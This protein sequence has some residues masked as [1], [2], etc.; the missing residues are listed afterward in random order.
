MYRVALSG[1]IRR[2]LALTFVLALALTPATTVW[3]QEY[4]VW[5]V[6]QSNAED[7]GDQL[8]IYTAG[9]WSEPSDVVP[10][11]A[12]AAGVGDGAGTRPHFLLFNTAHTHGLLANVASGHV[13]VIRASDRA[14]VASIDVGDQ[15]HAAMASPDDRWILVANQN[16]K[17][18]ARIEADFAN[19]QFA[20]D[21]SA[22]LDI[23][24]LQDDGN[25]D[26]API[27]PVMYVG[28]TGKAYV[29]LRG[30]GMYVVDTAATPM[31][32]TRSYSKDEIAPAGC[33]GVTGGNRVYINSGSARDGHLYVFDAATDD[34]I[35][36]TPTTQYGTDAHG[37]LLVADRYLWMGNRGL[38]DNVVILNAET[39]ELAGMIEDVGPGP[40][41]MDISP[42]G[43]LVFVTLRGPKALTGGPSA[44]GLTP[45]V[46]VLAV[47]QG[48]ASGYRVEF[49]PIGSQEAGSAADPHAV[50]VRRTHGVAGR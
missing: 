24:A 12:R 26:N 29:T 25:P 22:D 44:I 42:G 41:L 36:S 48:G 27:C 46:A 7:G 35:T 23:G 8:Y 17:R 30:G 32:V 38:G 39:L 43:D 47:D 20:Y 28:S 34:L 13:Y 40:D 10:L 9:S 1:A 45:G 16:G 50:A 5:T 15:A 6:D 21:P 19:E 3:A 33:G 14:I 2:I 49:I 31:R 18:L 11:G 4:E 37:M